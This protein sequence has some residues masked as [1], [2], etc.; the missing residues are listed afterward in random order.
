MRLTVWCTVVWSTTLTCEV[1]TDAFT[2]AAAEAL[3]VD[4]DGVCRRAG[5]G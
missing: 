2:A 1:R 4:F 5:K 3:E